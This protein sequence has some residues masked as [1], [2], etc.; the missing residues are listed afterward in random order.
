LGLVASLILVG[1]DYASD[2]SQCK[3]ELFTFTLRTGDAG[4]TKTGAETE[5][6]FPPHF[7]KR[8]L[9]MW[10]LQQTL[11]QRGNFRRSP[12]KPFK[13]AVCRRR[14]TRSKLEDSKLCWLFL[15]G[16]DDWKPSLDDFALA[17]KKY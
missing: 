1:N 4:E 2:E 8:H 9:S 3:L 14:R 12:G 11:F 6:L 16:L 17:A 5:A 7:T 13:I 15:C 10:S